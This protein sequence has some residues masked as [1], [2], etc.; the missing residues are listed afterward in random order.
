MII[1]LLFEFVITLLEILFGWV[2]FPQMPA[3]IVNSLNTLLDY[4]GQAMS[5]VWLVVPRQL[6]L[7]CLPVILVLENF[8]KIY[9]VIMWILRKIPAL[10]I[11]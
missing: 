8:D 9:S 4:M 6:V 1:K 10:G 7:V 5:L 3:E 2:S 11:S